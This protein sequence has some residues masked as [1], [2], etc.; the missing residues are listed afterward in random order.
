MN[1]NEAAILR[2]LAIAPLTTGGL[3]AAL[4]FRSKGSL[5]A[6]LKACERLRNQRVIQRMQTSRTGVHVWFLCNAH[7][8]DESSALDATNA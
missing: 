4:G 1:Q 3:T 7:S 8:A 2:L 5:S 6:V